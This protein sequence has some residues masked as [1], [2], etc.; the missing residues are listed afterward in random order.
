MPERLRSLVCQ[1]SLAFPDLRF[2][3]CPTSRLQSLL[4]EEG[5]PLLFGVIGLRA[6]FFH[7]RDVGRGIEEIAIITAVLDGH[8]LGLRLAALVVDRGIEEAAILAAVQVGVALRA[9]VV[10]QNLS[11]GEQLHGLPAIEAG[12]TDV[13]HGEILSQDAGRR[14][15]AACASHEQTRMSAPLMLYSQ[16]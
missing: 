14:S 9:G 3:A 13:A 11:A 4:L 6:A 12:K 7:Q 15:L 1:T 16:A 5:V 8:P 2:Q 10:L